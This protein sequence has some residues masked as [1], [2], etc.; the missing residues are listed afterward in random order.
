MLNTEVNF[1]IEEIWE[2]KRKNLQPNPTNKKSQFINMTYDIMEIRRPYRI[3]MSSKFPNLIFS[4]FSKKLVNFS[5]KL[6][7]TNQNGT[8]IIKGESLTSSR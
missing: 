2:M 4:N 3:E 5:K 1:A 7:T 8:T 6:E